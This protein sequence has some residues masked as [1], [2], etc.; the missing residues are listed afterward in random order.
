MIMFLGTHWHEAEHIHGV[1]YNQN[2]EQGGT[3]SL[4]LAESN[5]SFRELWGC[6]SVTGTVITMPTVCVQLVPHERQKQFVW[7]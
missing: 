1:S 5:S 4:G 7:W 3:S 2:L 6:A